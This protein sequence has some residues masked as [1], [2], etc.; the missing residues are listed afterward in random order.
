MNNCE[1]PCEQLLNV[2]ANIQFTIHQEF[3]RIDIVNLQFT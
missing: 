1:V 2:I 3:R